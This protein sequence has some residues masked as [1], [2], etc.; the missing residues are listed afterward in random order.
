[1]NYG[2]ELIILYTHFWGSVDVVE[3]VLAILRV[4]FKIILSGFCRG[5]ES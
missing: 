5:V 1:M 3:E 4:N 2:G